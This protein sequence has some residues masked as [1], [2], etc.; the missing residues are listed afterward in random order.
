MGVPEIAIIRAVVSYVFREESAKQAAAREGFAS[1]TL[2]RWLVDA[3]V[4]VRSSAEQRMLDRAHGRYNHAESIR[5]AWRRGSYDTEAVRSTRNQGDWGFA[6]VGKNNPFY[7]RRHSE[8]TRA[9]LSQQARARVIASVGE[10]GPEWTEEFRARIVTRD[11]G[12]CAICGSTKMLQVHHVDLDRTHSDPSNLLTLCAACHLGYH[13]RG[14]RAD[15]I[16]AAHAAML[17][18]EFGTGHERSKC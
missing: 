10:Y 2:R 5:A 3:D 18:R 17:A 11:G 8:E 6:R 16:A 1:D 12:V 14:E 7:G 13:G 15:K 4:H 9:R